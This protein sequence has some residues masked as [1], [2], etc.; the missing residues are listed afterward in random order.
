MMMML[1]IQ[2][3][4]EATYNETVNALKMYSTKK[5]FYW[6]TTASILADLEIERVCITP[7]TCWRHYSNG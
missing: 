2:Q 6:F 4:N 7:T 1:N 3:L 5:F